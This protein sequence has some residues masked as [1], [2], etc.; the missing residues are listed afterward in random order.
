VSEDGADGQLVASTESDELIANRG[1]F[2]SS[3]DELLVASTE[4]H[5][6]NAIRGQFFS[7]PD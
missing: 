1:Q 7:T 6:L 5:V 4:S 3:T 2:F